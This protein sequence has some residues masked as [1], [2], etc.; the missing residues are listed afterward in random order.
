MTISENKVSLAITPERNSVS[1]EPVSTSAG[2]GLV[3]TVTFNSETSVFLANTG[4]SPHFS[5]L[6]AADPVDFRIFPDGVVGR[7]YKNDLVKFVCSILRY[8]VRVEDTQVAAVAS[9]LFFSFSLKGLLAFALHDTMICGLTVDLAL[10]SYLSSISSAHLHTPDYVTLFG[11]V[12]QVV[13]F[14]WPARSAD[15]VDRL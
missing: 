12:A 7:I 4:K 6:L 5:V 13:G 9:N 1:A 11:F 3:I 10:D 14:V 2:S 15:S 8:P